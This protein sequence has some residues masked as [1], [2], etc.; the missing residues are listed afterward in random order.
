MT[1]KWVEPKSLK[2]LR[3]SRPGYRGEVKE[4]VSKA[5][6]DAWVAE[7]QAMGVASIVCLLAQ[8]HLDLYESLGVSLPEYYTKAGFDVSHVLAEDYCSPPLSAEQLKLVRKAYTKLRKPVLIHC[9]AGQDRTGCAV[10]HIVEKEKTIE[11][12][13][14]AIKGIFSEKKL[15][16]RTN[17]W[18]HALQ[19]LRQAVAEN[20]AL[21]K[22]W[23]GLKLYTSVSRRST[24]SLRFGGQEVAEIVIKKGKVVLRLNQDHVK[25]NRKYFG[26]EIAAKDIPWRGGPA[27][28]FRA[29]FAKLNAKTMKGL[30]SPEHQLETA[31][32][33]ALRNSPKPS[34]GP[35]HQ[36]QP[37]TIEG[38]PIQFPVPL[39][40]RGGRAKATRGY[41]DIVVRQGQR[42]NNLA[43]WELKAPDTYDSDIL[44]Q[45]YIYGCQVLLMLR[46]SSKGP[47]WY[48]MFGYSRKLPDN[49]TIDLV[50]CVH[51]QFRELAIESFKALQPE[52][53]K[54][55]GADKFRVILV[56]FDDPMDFPK[57]REE[58]LG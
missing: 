19:E 13:Y 14:D 49:L 50:L 17:L 4:P 15:W 21:V 11:P 48:A 35:F 38:I 24:F 56:H 18:L 9:S 16:S 31:V 10:A 3:S 6:V 8:D 34:E 39:S 1:I 53:S 58:V 52:I 40:A 22:Q 29:H 7:A 2:L 43:I 33:G 36:A 41:I 27:R 23:S 12:T 47:D 42:G 26:I 45:L 5:M 32:I 20:K 57:Y 44:S 30:R 55:K 46:E 51:R 28:R 54:P 37:V 25:N